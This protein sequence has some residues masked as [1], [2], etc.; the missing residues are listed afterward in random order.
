M[1]KLVAFLILLFLFLGCTK[2]TDVQIPAYIQIDGYNT[3]VTSSLG[4][5]SQNFTDILVYANGKTYGTYP[6]G[7][8]IPILTNGTTSFIIRGVVRMN[9]LDILRTDYEVMKGCDTIINVTPG[10]VTHVQ[11]VFEYFSTA[12]FV[13]INNFDGDSGVYGPSLVPTCGCNTST[14]I[15]YGPGFGGK[16]Q[17]LALKPNA[18]TTTASVQTNNTINLPTGGVGVYMELNY[19][20]N[21]TIQVY[22]ST[23]GGALT[24]CGGIYPSPIWR[25]MYLNLTEQVSSLQSTAYTVYFIATYDGKPNDQALIDNIKIVTAQ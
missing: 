19:Q 22:I 4:T 11:P 18:D 1:K 5:A 24:N 12:K 6:L 23:N 10:Q 13:W 3:K 17:C 9:G 7:A 21:V 20:S 14:A 16:N 25:K 15:I 2:Q 8:K